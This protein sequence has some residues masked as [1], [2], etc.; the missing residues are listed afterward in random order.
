MSESFNFDIPSRAI[1]IDLLLFICILLF[2]SFNGPFFMRFRRARFPV[3]QD[4]R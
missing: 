1:G 4:S 3:V 2:F